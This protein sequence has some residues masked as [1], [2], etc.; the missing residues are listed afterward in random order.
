MNLGQFKDMASMMKLAQE[1][2]KQQAKQDKMLQENNELLKR[3][4]RTLDE[5]LRELRSKK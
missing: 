4:A 5:I 1:A 3:I 2:K